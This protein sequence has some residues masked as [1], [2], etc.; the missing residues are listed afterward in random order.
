V[1]EIVAVS[2]IT[3]GSSLFFEH[4]NKTIDTSRIASIGFFM[5]WVDLIDWYLRANA[6]NADLFCK[7]KNFLKK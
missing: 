1:L 4:E 7:T 5:G 6:R 3:A 2:R